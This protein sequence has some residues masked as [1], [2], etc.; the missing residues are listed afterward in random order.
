M[1]IGIC[2]LQYVR[3][4][5]QVNTRL[6]LQQIESGTQKDFGNDYVHL[7]KQIKWLL[8]D[9]ARLRQMNDYLER[10]IADL[11]LH[12]PDIPFLN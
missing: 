4:Y 2:Y 6:T 8:K 10:E 12:I 11:R 3:D 7:Q 5:V 9:N 1:P